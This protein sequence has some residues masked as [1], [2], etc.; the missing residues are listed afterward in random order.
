M[1]DAVALPAP[2]A[3]GWAAGGMAVHS[4][5]RLETTM[6]LWL[7][8]EGHGAIVIDFRHH[9]YVWDTPIAEFPHDPASV[10]VGTQQIDHDAPPPFRLPA[11]DLDALLWLIGLNSFPD[12]LASWLRPGDKFR[13]RRHPDL[14]GVAC[15]DE[16]LRIIRALDRGLLFSV[17]R[18]AKSIDL[19]PT[20]VLPV[21][22]ALS[23]IGALRRAPSA[24]GAPMEPPPPPSDQPLS[25]VEKFRARLGLE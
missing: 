1:S 22:N 20:A 17:E 11:N 7:Q 21:I 23:L 16:Q 15:T 2:T 10:A 24:H 4:I 3:S 18:I 12:R 8:P 19:E 9:A 5:R 13:L 25:A 6:L 14:E